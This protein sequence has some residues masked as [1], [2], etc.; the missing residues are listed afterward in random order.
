MKYAVEIF[1]TDYTI[2]V[3]ELGRAAEDLGF[4]SLWFPE[5]THI[6]ASRK[7]PWPGG[8][9]LPKE[10]WHTL[11][12]FAALAAVAVVTSR[13][14]LGTGICLVVERDPIT[15]AKEVATVDF[16]S[17]GRFL[18]GVGGGWNYEEM[19]NHGTNPKLRWRIMRERI[20]AMK[21]IWTQENAE[22][23][24]RYV[25][26][27]PIWQWPKPVQKP[28]PPIVVGGNGPGTLDRV[29]EYGD[30]WMPIAG[31]GP[32]LAPRIAELRER[33]KAAG[34]GY[35]PVSIFGAPPRPDLVQTYKEIGV[36]RVIFR[37][38]SADRE[39]VLAELRKAA[40]VA[41]EVGE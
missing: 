5:H 19:E 37:L 3:T 26:F 22:F 12:P 31:R 24:G 33:A 15:T 40:Q 36:D 7:S 32:D 23:H 21:A 6:P 14:K 8:P 35:I 25:N 20:L 41:Q 11:D 38:P 39:T 28:H 4:E 2:A 18:F 29:L 10:Y 9:E 13:L 30:E 1:P 27:D 34:R 16:L 17:N